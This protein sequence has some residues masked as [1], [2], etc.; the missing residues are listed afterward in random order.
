MERTIEEIAAKMNALDLWETVGPFTWALKPQGTALPYFCTLLRGDNPLVKVRLLLLEGWQT[1]HDF[2]RTRTDRNFGFYLSPFEMA[3]FELVILASGAAKLF[4]HQPCFMPRE[5]TANEQG[6]CARLLWECYGVM[7][8]IESDRK[9]PLCFAAEQAMFSR[10]ERRS[11][12]WTDEALPIPKAPPYVENLRLSK[13]ELSRAKDLPFGNDEVWEVDFRFVPKLMTKEARPRCV[14]EFVA[15][16]AKTGTRVFEERVSP[17]LEGGLKAMWEMLPGRALFQILSRG[18]IPGEIRLLSGRLFRFLRPLCL[19][20]PFKL[21]LH[22][23]LP[24][25]QEGK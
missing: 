2:I 23:S 9:L 3:H 4:R 21:S 19:E 15:A 16:D 25:L 12:E 1:F 24:H 17:T 13:S 22:D 6:F 14:Y 20:L 7:L 10:V 8:R 5:A 18:R 11:G